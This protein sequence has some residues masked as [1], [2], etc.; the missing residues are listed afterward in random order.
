[1]FIIIGADGKEYGP[2][3]ADK[4]QG[5]ITTRRADLKTKARRDGETEWKTLGDFPE[6]AAPPAAPG[7]TAA[8]A[9]AVPAPATFTVPMAPAAGEARLADR[10]TRLVAQIIDFLAGC[11][12][13]IPGGVLLVLGGG[14]HGGPL[15]FAGIAVIVFGSLILL[16]IQIYL[17][18]TNGQTVGKKLMSIRIV[19][20]PDGAEAG[21]VK[22]FLLRMFV[23]GLI[24]AIPL[25]GFLYLLVD[26]CFIFRD[27]RRCI[28]DLIAGT[29][30]VT[31]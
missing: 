15:A 2:V 17:L 7:M 16:G 23:N 4:I 28:H 22:A 29:Q 13:G 21:F 11:V 3:P 25:L 5:W 14:R 26:I 31:A 9:P 30:V 19:T 6:F 20:W 18:T 12:A 1:M 10:G 24:T 27:D 8:P